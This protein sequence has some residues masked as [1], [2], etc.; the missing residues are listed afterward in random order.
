DIG[1]IATVHREL[2]AIRDEGCA[3]LLVS[4]DL[5]EVLTLADRVLVLRDGRV[6]GLVPGND[7]SER[8]LGELMLGAA[9]GQGAPPL[10]CPSGE[11]SATRGSGTS[12]SEF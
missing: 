11:P 2:F 6:A 12:R 9:A 8:A 7:A 1:A 3:V 4:L 10:S 5:D